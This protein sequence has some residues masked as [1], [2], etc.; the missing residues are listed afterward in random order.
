MKSIKTMLLGIAV[1]S[2]TSCC[3]QFVS[4]SSGID[5]ILSFLGLIIGLIL[6]IKG[7]FSKE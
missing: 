6:C 7:Y 5:D 1:L 3:I 2:V 4:S